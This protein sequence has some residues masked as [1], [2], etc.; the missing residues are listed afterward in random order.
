M[1]SKAQQYQKNQIQ[2]E[3]ESNNKAYWV[4]L[5]LNKVS[6]HLHNM[7]FSLEIKDFSKAHEL[8][9][10]VHNIIELGLLDNLDLEKG[11]EVAKNLQIFYL[12]SQ[13]V[14]LES[15]MKKNPK[16]LKKIADSYATMA[17]SWLELSK[18]KDL[19]YEN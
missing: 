19:N 1:L 15:R 8:S 14:I 18:Q 7:V 6:E 12:S 10:K 11:G 16:D 3:V 17:E 2:F 9:T 4:Y 13:K 5:L